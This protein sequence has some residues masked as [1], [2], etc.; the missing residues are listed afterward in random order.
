MPSTKHVSAQTVS[1]II[2][3]VFAF[4]V[5]GGPGCMDVMPNLV[6]QRVREGKVAQDGNAPHEPRCLCCNTVY[7]YLDPS[8]VIPSMRMVQAETPGHCN[9]S[10]SCLR[11]GTPT[12]VAERVGVGEHNRGKAGK[13]PLFYGGKKPASDRGEIGWRS[14]ISISL[15]HAWNHDAS[16]PTSATT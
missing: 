3:N 16:P 12:I 7:E 8:N 5:L 6:I 15:V 14:P 11:G 9:L 4:S 2:C 13:V 1:P 10:S